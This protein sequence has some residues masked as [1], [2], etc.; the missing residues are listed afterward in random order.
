MK[1]K[2]L[3]SSLMALSII[4]T[5]SLALGT[6]VQAAPEQTSNTTT[7]NEETQITN[8]DNKA[9]LNTSKM[10]PRSDSYKGFIFNLP[11]INENQVVSPPSHGMYYQMHYVNADLLHVR[12]GPGMGYDIIGGVTQGQEVKVIAEKNGWSYIEYNVDTS[13][14]KVGWVSSQYLIFN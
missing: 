5:S 8:H 12:K 6:N 10:S 11:I 7:V 13:R 3:L 1:S 4:A 14:S 9:K 2:K